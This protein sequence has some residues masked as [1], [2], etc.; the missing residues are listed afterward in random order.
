[1]LLLH[2]A[3]VTDHHGH[4]A[5]RSG[6]AN[7]EV[8]VVVGPHSAVDL[9]IAGLRAFQRE[10]VDLQ[11]RAGG[12]P[13]IGMEHAPDHSQRRIVGRVQPHGRRQLAARIELDRLRQV[14][15]RFDVHVVKPNRVDAADG[16][17]PPFAAPRVPATV[18]VAPGAG[19][20]G[21]GPWASADDRHQR[22]VERAAVRRFHVANQRVGDWRPGGGRQRRRQQRG[23]RGKQKACGR[24][25]HERHFIAPPIRLR[26]HGRR[27]D[28]IQGTPN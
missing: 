23:E 7:R 2:R 12:R 20:R 13:A 22:P 16:K 4:S 11:R 25:E 27:L 10:I 15:G 17:L 1:M 9:A 18:G 5:D 19:Q 21:A 14:A 24:A 26:P 8:A 3:D 6:G 28:A